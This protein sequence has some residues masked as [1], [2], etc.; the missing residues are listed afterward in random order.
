MAESV[1]HGFHFHSASLRGDARVADPAANV[2]AYAGPV[3]SGESDI[4]PVK[5]ETITSRSYWYHDDEGHAPRR[6]RPKL[7]HAWFRPG[8]DLVQ[9]WSTGG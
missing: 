6:A 4:K 3:A 9:C 2:D 7:V 5:D 1:E 8:S